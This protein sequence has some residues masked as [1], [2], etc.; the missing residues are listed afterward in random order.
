[1]TG[2][3]RRSAER[4]PRTVQRPRGVMDD[5]VYCGNPTGKRNPRDRKN[6][7]PKNAGTSA[8]TA[9]RPFHGG[10]LCIITLLENRTNPKSGVS[11][12]QSTKKDELIQ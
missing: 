10:P 12:G 5:R 1:V 8:S 9:K 11:D 3:D 7:K 6:F 2:G 4:C